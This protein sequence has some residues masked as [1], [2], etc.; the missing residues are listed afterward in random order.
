MKNIIKNLIFKIVPILILIALLGCAVVLLSKVAPFEV[1]KLL[2]ANHSMR[3]DYEN[4][5]KKFDDGKSAYILAN[6]ING[7][8]KDKEL[9]QI[10]KDIGEYLKW[11]VS[12]KD[13]VGPY[14]AKYV[15]FDDRFLQ[16]KPFFSADTK[17]LVE[18]SKKELQTELWKNFLIKED[19]SSFITSFVFS[20]KLPVKSEKKVVLKLEKFLSELEKKYPSTKF[21][22][23]GTKVAS[24]AFLKEMEF[25][26]KVITPILLLCIGI[27]L[28][29]L[30][31]SFEILIWNFVVMIVCYVSTLILIIL[32]EGGL[33]PYSNFAL[34]FSFMVATTDLIH[35]F[36]RYQRIEGDVETRIK[37]TW[38]IAYVPC[39]LTSLTTAAGF[40]A[41]IINQ[42]LPIRYFG[43]Y[44]AFACLLEWVVIF[45]LL[46]ILFRIY[47]F[48]APIYRPNIERPMQWYLAFLQKHSSKIVISSI[49]FVIVGGLLS[50]R[51]YVDDNFYTKF[52]DNHSL[53]K[54]IQSFSKEMHFVGS[55]DV[56]ISPRNVDS[57]FQKNNMDKIRLFE[58]ELKTNPIV[59]RITSLRVLND[60]LL[61]T[62]NKNTT[63]KD[64]ESEVVKRSIFL[65]MNNYQVLRDIYNESTNESRSVVFLSS[66]A[67]K[68]FVLVYDHIN[69]LKEKY[70]DVLDIK[71]SGF[72]NIRHF[73]NTTVIRNFFE[74]FALSFFL[75][76]LC[77][78]YL[79]RS[80]LWAFFALL[81]STLPLVVITGL[82]GAFSIPVDSNLA[83]LICVAF[84]TSGD[85]TVHL[86]YVIQQLKDRNLKYL[87]SLQLAIQQI[88]IPLVATSAIFI[89]CLPCF[90]LGNLKLFDQMGIFLSLSF[91][92]AFISDIFSF[93]AFYVKKD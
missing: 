85:N 57:V 53:S 36:G 3:I 69:K 56:I 82:M 87:D 86:T 33:G 60:K 81:P 67:T 7:S 2:P 52:K 92:M 27:F 59:S 38:K 5:L 15:S 51:I 28:F 20:S 4:Y 41:L 84:G 34:M 66:L 10:S 74:S 29:F 23:T 46:P 75:T 44:C 19:M 18:E 49:F 40:I 30:Y 93:P 90:L 9:Y 62:I 78:I 26:L 37:T 50:F 73:I 47:N 14:N 65:L 39:L 64:V 17:E 76:Y 63:S 68:D 12:F 22:V 35:F 54:T 80:L 48:S 13:I 89:C 6:K 70:S 72:A 8:F 55:I 61:E 77:F 58:N 83:I 43:I 71:I 25:N 79:Y 88:G 45:Y 1:Q 11:D 31:R 91:L 42:N 21:Y 32:V 24:V 16:L